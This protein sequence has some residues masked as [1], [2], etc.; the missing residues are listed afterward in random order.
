MLLN[1]AKPKGPREMS[2]MF[3]FYMKRNIPLDFGYTCV[4]QCVKSRFGIKSERF[5]G[6]DAARAT[7]PL[8]SG[9]FGYGRHYQGI[10]ACLWIIS[11]D[12]NVDAG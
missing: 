11:T 2:S 12:L 7:R 8:C 10:H 6:P 5:S 1:E 9:R 4:A 3:S